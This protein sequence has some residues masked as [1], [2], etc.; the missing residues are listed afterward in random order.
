MVR[1]GA[2]GAIACAIAAA[3]PCSV[4]AQLSPQMNAF[5]SSNGYA[6]YAEERLN[7]YEPAPLRAKCAQIK[8]T[9]RVR[10]AVFDPPPTF[11]SGVV[12]ETGEWIDQLKVDR[13]GTPAQRNLYL[14]ARGKGQLQAVSMLPGETITSPV[15]QRDALKVVPIVALDKMKCEAAQV[16]VIDT[17]VSVAPAPNRPWQEEWTFGGCDQMIALAVDF[18]PDGKGGTTFSVKGQ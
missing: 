9:G 1:F 4:N 3:L 17:K 14:I 13:C 16:A 6:K 18:V 5:L 10:S 12:P 7:E 2:F 15:L 11:P 8:L